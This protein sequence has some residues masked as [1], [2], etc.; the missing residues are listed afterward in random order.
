M[1]KS[2][3]TKKMNVSKQMLESAMKAAKAK[4][5]RS[6]PLRESLKEWFSQKGRCPYNEVV[7]FG[8]W[9]ELMLRKMAV[10]IGD[11]SLETAD[12][13]FNALKVQSMGDPIAL[14][15]ASQLEKKNVQTDIDCYVEEG[16]VYA[17]VWIK[18][19]VVDYVNEL[20]D[21]VRSTFRNKGYIASICIDDE[22]SSEVTVCAVKDVAKFFKAQK[23]G[24]R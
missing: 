6:K 16:K 2:E 22:D 5:M 10:E 12:N 1:T 14:K 8:D 15:C 4:V 13:L 3:R 24:G 19:M 23:K 17:S 7:D 21:E 18:H 11:T 20:A 9:T